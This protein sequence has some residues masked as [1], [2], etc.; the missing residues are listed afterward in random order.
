MNSTYLQPQ[1]A[2]DAGL[3]HRIAT[4]YDW[5]EASESY[6][7]V[8]LIQVPEAQGCGSIFT[9]VN[10]YIKWVRAMMNQEPPISEEIYR[11]LIR[12]RI[13][14]DPDNN[15]PE[16][17]EHASPGLYAAG[18]STLYKNG[19]QIVY[20]NGGV[21]GFGSIHFFLPEFKFGGVAVGNSNA[22]GIVA[23]RL[24]VELVFDVLGIPLADDTFPDWS[25]FA[26]SMKE[27]EE[28]EAREL[29]QELCPGID[30]PEPQKRPLSEYVGRY[31]NAGYHGMNVEIRDDNLFINATGRS[32]A[33]T[34]QLE[35][36]CDQLKYVATYTDY[37]DENKWE[38]AAEFIVSNNHVARM[39]LRL[40]DE[41]DHL[42]WFDRES[43]K[44]WTDGT[45]ALFDPGWP[46][47]ILT[48]PPT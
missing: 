27:E 4:P 23:D 18:W 6:T 43:D 46:Q 14:E 5:N 34:L 15:A 22:A 42:I 10:D 3:E 35:H 17:G 45:Y 19:H 20:H 16:W 44:L 2:I 25:T 29:R 38:L 13:I 21:S 7:T 47:V 11:G 32:Q 1:S 26:K 24:C 36:L 48:H 12:P 30:Q 28:E 33:F 31:W 8:K 39:G 37:Y 41:L 40:E 9:S